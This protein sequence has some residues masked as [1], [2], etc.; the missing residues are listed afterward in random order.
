MSNAPK[1]AKAKVSA[2]PSKSVV[3]RSSGSKNK[4]VVEKKAKTHV[5]PKLT[6]AQKLDSIGEDEIFARIANCEFIHKI[7]ESYGISAGQFHAWLNNHAEMYVRAR[8]QQADKLVADML[9]IADDGLNDTYTADDGSERTNQDVIGRSRLRVEARKWLA[10]KMNAKKYGD[11]LAV[12]GADD[13]PGI[14]IE[15]IER[16]IVG[17]KT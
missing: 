8:E 14:K 1:T 4:Q 10:G 7:A 13:M 5:V 11:K 3:A 12:G 15:R 9:Q 6:A 16:I 17:K 2:K